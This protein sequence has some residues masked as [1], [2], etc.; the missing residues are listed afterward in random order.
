MKVDRGM[1]I[2]PTA[3]RSCYQNRLPDHSA[4]TVHQSITPRG[5]K[6]TPKPGIAAKASRRRGRGWR[7]PL[8]QPNPLPPFLNGF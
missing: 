1:G 3:D 7:W 5:A 6:T 4:L 2:E 8:G